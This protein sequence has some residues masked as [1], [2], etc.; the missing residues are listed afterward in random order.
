MTPGKHFPT[1]RGRTPHV[2]QRIQQRRRP[3]KLS[4]Q[5]RTRHEGLTAVR[6]AA[7]LA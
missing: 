7:V 5:H 3:P 1:G 4:P 2:H 6:Y